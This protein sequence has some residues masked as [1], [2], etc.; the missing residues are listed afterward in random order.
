YFTSP[1]SGNTSEFLFV[2]A[3]RHVQERVRFV[4]AATTSFP[5]ARNTRTAKAGRSCRFMR[6]YLIN[7]RPRPDPGRKSD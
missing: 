7:K 6:R 5:C 3:G 4:A 1:V 2:P